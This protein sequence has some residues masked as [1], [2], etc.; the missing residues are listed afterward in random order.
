MNFKMRAQNFM[1]H[2]LLSLADGLEVSEIW[3]GCIKSSTKANNNCPTATPSSQCISFRI[4]CN[5]LNTLTPQWRIRWGNS[6]FC[7]MLKEHLITF[8]LLGK[9]ILFCHASGKYSQTF[10]LRITHFS[11]FPIPMAVF[12]QHLFYQIYHI[13]NLVFT[14]DKTVWFL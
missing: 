13:L 14:V 4:E 11:F 2:I 5:L 10:S 12:F 1:W 9:D 7:Q 8:L 3:Q 6:S